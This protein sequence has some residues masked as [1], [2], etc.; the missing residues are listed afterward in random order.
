MKKII[1]VTGQIGA[2]K[3]LLMRS[4]E[5]DFP[6]KYLFTDEIAHRIMATGNI[7]HELVELFGF[8]FSMKKSEDRKRIGKVIFASKSKKQA[9]E[10]IVHPAVRRYIQDCI[11]ETEHEFIFIESALPIDIELTATISVVCSDDSIRYNRIK[12][13][14]KK[15]LEQIELID[16][17][18][19]SYEEFCRAADFIIDT[20]D[21]EIPDINTSL[22]QDWLKA[23]FNRN[24]NWVAFTGSFLPFTYG[25][26]SIVKQALVSYDR[27]YI[28]QALNPEKIAMAEK[29]PLPLE[30][31]LP[32]EF[33]N[34]VFF[35][36]P[37][38]KLTSFLVKE[39]GC[40]VMIRGIRNHEDAVYE[41]KIFDIN[42]RID[43]SVVT[44]VYFAEP[45]SKMISSSLYRALDSFPGTKG[46]FIPSYVKINT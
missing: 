24:E 45:E 5:K 40:R 9:M 2:G 39:L 6:G 7:Y 14:R 46:L 35:V 16:K 42:H 8:E 30:E 33:Q 1:Y 36:E 4:L 20:I 25:H 44:A 17:S 22:L 28:V 23:K 10:E 12:A 15:T 3:S 41:N 37:T 27:V 43:P 31:N 38:Q 29:Y 18:Q 13:H 19:R 26:E 34:K 32:M 21:S 11:A